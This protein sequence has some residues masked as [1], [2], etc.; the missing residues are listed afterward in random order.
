MNLELKRIFYDK[1]STE[2]IKINWNKNPIRMELFLSFLTTN[3]ERSHEHLGSTTRWTRLFNKENS[4]IVSGGVVEGVEYLDSLQFG[5]KLSNLY[6]NYV[7]PFYLFEILTKEG[8]AFFLDYYADDID[9]VVVTEKVGIS[10]QERKLTNSKAIFQALKQ[11]IE[12]LK[13]NCKSTNATTNM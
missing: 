6:N 5:V 4:L 2:K 8:Q 11:E 9:T 12:L 13:L 3:T 7:K 10:I 1:L